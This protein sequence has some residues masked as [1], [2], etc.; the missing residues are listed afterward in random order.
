VVTT[1]K[2]GDFTLLQLNNAPPS[3]SLFLGWSST[4]IATTDG[5]QV[6]RVSNP[7]FG[8]QVYSQHNVDAT[9]PACGGWPRG[10]WIYSRDITG[11]IDGG[12]S[13]S[14]IINASS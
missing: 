7:D 11:A 5:F 4:P 2:K 14:P 12:S 13:G 8:P 10:S 6:Y 9:F 3:G 1:A